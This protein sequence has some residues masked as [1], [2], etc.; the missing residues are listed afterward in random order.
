[1]RHLIRLTLITLALTA[2]ATTTGPNTDQPIACMAGSDCDEKWSRAMQWLEKNTSSK[3]TAT[4]SQLSAVESVENAK[5]A[6]EVTKA[7]PDDGKSYTITMR[8][9]CAAENCDDLVGRLNTSFY[10]YVL[11]R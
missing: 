2:C 1:M 11:G 10:D 9:W 8:A 6:F 5:P 3:V 4:D 7:T